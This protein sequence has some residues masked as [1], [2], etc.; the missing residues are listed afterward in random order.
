ML[1]DMSSHSV[2][3]DIQYTENTFTLLKA[4]FQVLAELNIV[5]TYYSA[6]IL[7]GKHPSM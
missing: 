5:F 6:V 7:F 1:K 4:L 2:L 3:P